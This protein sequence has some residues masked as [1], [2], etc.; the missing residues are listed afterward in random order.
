MPGKDSRHECWEA[1]RIRI[2]RPPNAEQREEKARV[3]GELKPMQAFGF[4]LGMQIRLLP[5]EPWSQELGDV[6]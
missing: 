3:A 5:S 2:K 4:W 6:P 1:E